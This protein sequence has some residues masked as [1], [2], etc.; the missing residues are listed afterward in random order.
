MQKNDF[1]DAAVKM[2]ASRDVGA[3]IFCA[4]LRS[5]GVEA[6]L[7]CSLQP[8]PFNVTAIPTI[9]QKRGPALTVSYADGNI[10]MYDEESEEDISIDPLSNMPKP[11][12][13]TGPRSRFISGIQPRLSQTTKSHT[14]NSGSISQTSIISLLIYFYPN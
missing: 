12:G 14:P 4:L 6:R 3:Q 11:V 9:V 5:A 2:E 1:L 10:P 8:L 13:S 7:V